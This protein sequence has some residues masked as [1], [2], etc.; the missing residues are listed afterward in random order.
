MSSSHLLHL[1]VCL[2]NIPDLSRDGR[3]FFFY[4]TFNEWHTF[5]QIGGGALVP[6]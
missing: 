5:M 6:L 3:F 2:S 1:N 4:A